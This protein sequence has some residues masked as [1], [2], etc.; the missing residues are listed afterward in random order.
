MRVLGVLGW[1]CLSTLL[2]IGS[3]I[4]QDRIGK[5]KIASGDVFI[6]RSG[7]R[8]AAEP[9]MELFETDVVITGQNSA[10]GMTFEDNSRISIG[11]ESRVEMESFNAPG[12][13]GNPAFDIRL[14]SGSLTASSGEITKARPLAMRVL[15]PTTVLGVK[16][17]FFAVRV[18]DG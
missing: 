16:G 18:A 9:G 3:A 14:H 10:V 12:Q 5:V 1:I 8:V 11:P 17:T 13:G 15:T 4:G 7:S 2:S 6:E